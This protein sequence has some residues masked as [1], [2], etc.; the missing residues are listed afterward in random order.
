MKWRFEVSVQWWR[1]LPWRRQADMD[2]REA[3]ELAEQRLTKSQELLD[4][5]RMAERHLRRHLRRDRLGA[6]IEQEVFGGR[7]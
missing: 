5:A 4:R 3:V 1:W 7:R 2:A 6:M